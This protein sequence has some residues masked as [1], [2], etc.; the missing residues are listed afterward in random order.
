MTPEQR[1]HI[2]TTVAILDMASA[3][4]KDKES[5]AA[6]VVGALVFPVEDVNDREGEGGKA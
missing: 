1:E 4:L 6:A 2:A 3:I 5:C